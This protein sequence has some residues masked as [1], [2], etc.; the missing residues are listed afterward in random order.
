MKYYKIP[1]SE[2]IELLAS[3]HYLCA[4]LSGG[5]GNWVWHDAAVKAYIKEYITENNLECHYLDLEFDDLGK[6]SLKHYEELKDY[7]KV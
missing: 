7:K 5:V 1:E 4:L 2:L 3:E 6:Y